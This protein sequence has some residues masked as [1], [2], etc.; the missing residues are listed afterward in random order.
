[1]GLPALL[2]ETPPP[3][4]LHQLTWL[5]DAIGSSG[6]YTRLTLSTLPALGA[7][8]FPCSGSS[9]GPRP[10]FMKTEHVIQIGTSD[11]TQP[12]IRSH[13]FYL[14]LLSLD[15]TSKGWSPPSAV[16]RTSKTVMSLGLVLSSDVKQSGQGLPKR[17]E[18]R[19]LLPLQGQ[20]V[21]NTS[22]NCSNTEPCL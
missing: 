1:M 22:L 6:L 5:S 11:F 19:E 15:F 10:M 20:L 9:R 2:A 8:P 16:P 13:Y 12:R 18:S 17:G 21:C 14:S 3:S 4:E 7:P